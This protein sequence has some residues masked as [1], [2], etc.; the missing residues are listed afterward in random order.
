[1]SWSLTGYDGPIACL[2]WLYLSGLHW[3]V[4]IFI[5]YPRRMGLGDFKPS[6][7]TASHRHRGVAYQL[8]GMSRGPKNNLFCQ[9]CPFV[10]FRQKIPV[11]FVSAKI[12]SRVKHISKTLHSKSIYALLAGHISLKLISKWVE[13]G[14]NTTC[15]T[16]FLLILGKFEQICAC[17]WGIIRSFSRRSPIER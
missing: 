9:N 11:R 3:T 4:E 16:L 12:P 10:H 13:T 8:L 17:L 6:C 14:Q 5:R 2:F 7:L 15:P 1:M